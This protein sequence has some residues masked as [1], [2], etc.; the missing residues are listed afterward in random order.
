[1]SGVLYASG[2]EGM[3]IIL[4]R[5]TGFNTCASLG[6]S[7]SLTFAFYVL[8]MPHPSS[9]LG[10]GPHFEKYSQ[11]VLEFE[12][13]ESISRAFPKK[14]KQ[15]STISRLLTPMEVGEGLAQT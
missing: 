13:K 4:S 8:L 1:M 6:V 2:W 3:I 10:R 14:G 11:N 15:N 12:G 9:G 5:Y 7:I